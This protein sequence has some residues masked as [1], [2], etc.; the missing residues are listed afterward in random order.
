MARQFISSLEHR[1]LNPMMAAILG[2]SMLLGAA[3]LVSA[4]DRTV[5]FQNKTGQDVD[6]LHIETKQ[7]VTIT[8]KD[9]FTGSRGVDG[10]NKHN[11]YGGTVEKEPV[12]GP[13]NE[14]VV[15]F[16][17][18]SPNITIKKWWWTKGGNARRDG[19]RVGP[20]NGDD[21]G[22]TLA[23]HGGPAS[24]DGRVLVSIDGRE[25]VFQTLAGLPPEETIR[26]FANFCNSF[27]DFEHEMQLIHITPLDPNH[28]QALGNVLG[29]ADTALRVE[30]LQRDRGQQLELLPVDTGIDL[31]VEGNCPG[32]VAAIVT[33]ALPGAPVMLAY[34]FNE[35]FPTQVPGCPGVNFGLRNAVIVGQLPADNNGTAV[36]QGNVPA[37]ACGRLILQAA[38]QARCILSNSAGL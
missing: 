15:K 14:A 35:N 18:G 6:D 26:M 21:G 34:S 33:N 10:G 38:E 28:L 20:I 36:F 30:L 13:P 4:G 8:Q 12:G 37:V 3:T 24:G 1:S 17:S 11:L 7:G 25:E 22:V 2:A 16:T 19:Q 32:R 9:P 27:Y 23:C 5:R 31:T 29:N